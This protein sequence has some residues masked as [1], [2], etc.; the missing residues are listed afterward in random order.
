MHYIA[1]LGNPGQQYQWTRHNAGR[2]AV[3][4]LFR[5][6][7]FEEW[8][9]NDKIKALVSKGKIEDESVALVLPEIFM[10]SSGR[11]LAKLIVR[12]AAK[13]L[14]VLHDDLD[15]PFGEIRVSFGRGAGGHKGVL[16][17]IRALKTKDFTRVRIG[18][19]VASSRNKDL[20]ER[21]KDKDFVLRLLTMSE[22]KRLEP[23]LKKAAA[24]A[25]M[26]VANGPLAAMNSFN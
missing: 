5:D 15:L 2:L 6:Q 1:G 20:P 13:R 18:I 4:S 7:N 22:K 24:A 26:T 17:I 12:Q 3:E 16:S 23:A 8:R 9:F 19:G 21:V 14:V 11:S 10:N 25:I